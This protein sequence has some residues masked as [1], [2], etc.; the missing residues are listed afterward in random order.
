MKTQGYGSQQSL[1]RGVLVLSSKPSHVYKPFMKENV[2]LL[3]NYV[4]HLIDHALHCVERHPYKSEGAGMVLASSADVLLARHAFLPNE[5]LLKRAA[6]SF[7]FV[8][9]DQLEITW[10]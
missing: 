3:R 5:L 2:A 4:N 8:P 7:P 6:H 1:I 9:K 10:R